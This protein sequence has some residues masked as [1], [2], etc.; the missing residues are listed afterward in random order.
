MSNW[1]TELK[2]SNLV[3]KLI[4]KYES[5]YLKHQTIVTDPDLLNQ[6]LNSN[7]F[8]DNAVRWY[9]QNN[10]IKDDLKI[11]SDFQSATRLS[12][13]FRTLTLTLDKSDII[14]LYK[15]KR[16]YQLMNNLDCLPKDYNFLFDN[17]NNLINIIFNNSHVQEFILDLLTLK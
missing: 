8:T 11:I 16:L 13:K 6:F 15:Q 7:D 1:E 14:S 9:S 17:K 12:I 2:E 4:G 3:D 5:N 10:D